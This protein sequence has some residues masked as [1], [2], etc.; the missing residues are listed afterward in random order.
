MV[1]VRYDGMTSVLMRAYPNP[2]AGKK[3]TVEIKGFKGVNDIPIQ[4]YDM[5]GKPVVE[6]ILTTS[7]SGSLKEELVF[8]ETLP[9]GLYILKAGPSL[10]LMQ[11]I[12]VQ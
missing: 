10:K 3:I 9:A 6:R 12:E 7:K 11:K 8:D 1:A 5:L 2:S 4:I